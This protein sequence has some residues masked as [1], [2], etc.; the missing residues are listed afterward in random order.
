MCPFPLTCC[1]GCGEQQSVVVT[2][3]WEG[4]SQEMVNAVVLVAFTRSMVTEVSGL[5]TVFI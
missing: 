5:R 4:L 2:A 1:S 3:A